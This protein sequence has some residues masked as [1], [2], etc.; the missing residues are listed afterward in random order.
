MG[1]GGV[2]DGAVKKLDEYFKVAE[3]ATFLGIAQNTL[4]KYADEG[5]IP[6]HVNRANGYRLFLR[7]DLERF[8]KQTAQQV[9]PARP[10]KAK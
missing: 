9:R 10:K 6:V 8:L 3:A 1:S 2:G 5:R 7:E 4:R